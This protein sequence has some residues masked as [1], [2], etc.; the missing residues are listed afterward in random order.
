MGIFPHLSEDNH[1]WVGRIEFE[2]G[3][4]KSITKQWND[5]SVE[6]GGLKALLFGL[7]SNL[8]QKGYKIAQISTDA[9]RQPTYSGDVIILAM[10]N[11][12]VKISIQNQLD[13]NR[14][15][16]VVDEVLSK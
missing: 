15:A 11:R 3:R 10:T 12:K 6:A 5:H 1:R 13:T 14:I 2:N 4:V 9:I 16:V 7:I 8:I